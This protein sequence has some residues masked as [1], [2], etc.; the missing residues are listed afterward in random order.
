MAVAGSLHSLRFRTRQP[1]RCSCARLP[2][3]APSLVPS[4]SSIAVVVSVPVARPPCPGISWFLPQLLLLRTVCPASAPSAS[5]ILP[6][7]SS[8]LRIPGSNL[9]PTR[10]AL[11]ISDAACSLAYLSRT[12]A[13]F[14]LFILLEA[15]MISRDSSQAD[16]T[17]QQFRAST[18]HAHTSPV[19]LSLVAY[20]CCSFPRS[21]PSTFLPT[22]SPVLNALKMKSPENLA[23]AQSEF[24]RTQ[25]TTYL[26]VDIQLTPIYPHS[27][28]TPKHQVARPQPSTFHKICLYNNAKESLCL[29][30]IYSVRVSITILHASP[31]VS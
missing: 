13:F 30:I 26:L 11:G 20:L 21:L 24:R 12:W 6:A 17:R 29:V 28:Q 8:V 14:E 16:C 2:H 3:P 31:L 9:F 5:C 22:L 25:S 15:H 27:S 1:L 19:L 23:R 18:T 10:T 4:V 7:C